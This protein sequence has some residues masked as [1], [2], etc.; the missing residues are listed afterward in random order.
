MYTSL[1]QGPEGA[2]GDRAHVR[3]AEARDSVQYSR[4][5][6]ANMSCY[7]HHGQSTLM[8]CGHQPSVGSL[9]SHH[10]CTDHYL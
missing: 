2:K 6:I 10:L 4:V 1:G 3:G 7:L 8:D 9:G 5:T